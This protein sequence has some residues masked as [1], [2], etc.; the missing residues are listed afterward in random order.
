MRYCRMQGW[1]AQSC[2]SSGSPASSVIASRYKERHGPILPRARNAKG[3][4]REN[5]LAEAAPLAAREL[6]QST[7][8]RVLH[9]VFGA[10]HACGRGCWD[11]RAAKN[12][13]RTIEHETPSARGRVALAL[14]NSRVLLIRIHCSSEARADH[15]YVENL[16]CTGGVPVVTKQT[17][18]RRR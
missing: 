12:R 7:R 17:V 3:C 13:S 15:V 16:L 1:R 6:L 8:K 18:L 14:Q 2:Q 10:W 11:V 4:A 9:R 5:E